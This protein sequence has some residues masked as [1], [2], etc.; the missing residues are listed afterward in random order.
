MN[1]QFTMK[2]SWVQ[3]PNPVD[4]I[5]RKPEH[6]IF[7][8]RTEKTHNHTIAN[9]MMYFEYISEKGVEIPHVCTSACT[10]AHP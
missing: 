9:V 1:V 2:P 10:S 3:R 8:H 5:N 6:Q 7:D 4:R